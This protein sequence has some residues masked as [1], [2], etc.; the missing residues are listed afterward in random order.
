MSVILKALRAQQE[1]GGA[2]PPA[3]GDG[4]A[5][6]FQMDSVTP[7]PTQ[8]GGSG[9][10]KRTIILLVVL[11]V[12]IVLMVVL[13]LTREE[14][15]APAPRAPEAVATPAP[16]PAPIPAVPAADVP[17]IPGAT[18]A[19]SPTPVDATNDLQI[20]R[21]QYKAGQYD[22][23]I[24][25]FQKAIDKDPNNAAIHNDFGLV[26]LK[27]ELFTSAENHFAKAMELDDTCAE[28]YNN[29]GY[30]KTILNQPVEAE[31]ICRRLLACGQSIRMPILIW[32]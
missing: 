26:L 16:P 2:E 3:S 28:C 18:P 30:L 6:S 27:K 8:G 13:R 22:D 5:S 31:N 21:S 1:E 32:V 25:S 29:L 10:N 4:G 11:L 9:F 24:K 23:S 19:V 14:E 15:S 17:A 20:A 12:S 7:G